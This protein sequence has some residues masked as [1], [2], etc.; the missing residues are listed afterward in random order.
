[1]RP[2]E[3]ARR[4]WKDNVKVY[5]RARRFDVMGCILVACGGDKTDFVVPGNETS[6]FI[7]CGSGCGFLCTC[8]LFKDSK[9]LDG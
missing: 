4:K 6:G 8:Y 3:R 9:E 1:M 2:L 7:E 5:L